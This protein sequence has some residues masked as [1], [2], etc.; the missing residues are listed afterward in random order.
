[1]P[2]CPKAAA[3]GSRLSA[4]SSRSRTALNSLRSG[5]CRPRWSSN[6]FVGAVQ[7][8]LRHLDAQLTRHPLIDD[9]LIV[10]HLLNGQVARL[11]SLQYLV[12]VAGNAAR[13]ILKVRA[14]GHQ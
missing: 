2:G 13:D 3:R 1:M 12:D 8:F 6:H 10:R 9:E 14:I 5:H 7:K 11:G 4:N